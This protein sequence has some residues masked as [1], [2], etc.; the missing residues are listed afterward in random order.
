MRG[1]VSNPGA[2]CGRK[3]N[4]MSDSETSLAPGTPEGDKQLVAVLLA[5]FNTYRTEIQARS[6]QQATLDNLNITAIGIIA[7]YY[8]SAS[9]HA[10]ELVLLVI[11]IL[12]PLL[13]IIWCDHAINIGKLGRFLE[14]EIIPALDKRLNYPVP[15]YEKSVREFEKEL[16]P[17]FVLLIAPRL[18]LYGILPVMAI[19]VA[20]N[21]AVMHGPLFWGLA[22]IGAAVILLFGGYAASILF[23]DIWKKFSL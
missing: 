8:F 19:I 18:V 15:D 23:S 14:K 20:Y 7:G 16:W 10:S 22:A 9:Q 6:A 17:R 1:F 11:P 4:L 21:A 13:G 2:L 5:Q 12:S 3:N